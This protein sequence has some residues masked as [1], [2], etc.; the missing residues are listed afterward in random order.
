MWVISGGVWSYGLWISKISTIAKHA[1]ASLGT[2]VTV[3]PIILQ[4]HGTSH[5]Y[6]TRPLKLT[7][8][9]C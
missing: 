1:N 5:S 7:D 8:V 3:Q 6:T 4:V 9:N 2:S